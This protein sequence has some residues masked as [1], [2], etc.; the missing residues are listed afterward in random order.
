MKICTHLYMEMDL[1]KY[2]PIQFYLCHKDLTRT[3]K[4]IYHTTHH[5]HPSI[6][7]ISNEGRE[8]EN[9]KR[10]ICQAVFQSYLYQSPRNS[11]R[12]SA[13]SQPPLSPNQLSNFQALL[14]IR[15]LISKSNRDS[16]FDSWNITSSY[17]T[18]ILG[19]WTR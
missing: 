11:N 4:T 19:I 16:G 10:A 6:M 9:C 7:N 1:D 2:Y 14:V 12:P 3:R 5:S 13:L 8:N 18:N 17:P 15:F